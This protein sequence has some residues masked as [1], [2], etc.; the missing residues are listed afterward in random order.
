MFRDVLSICLGFQF[1][2]LVFQLVNGDVSLGYHHQGFTE[3]TKTS[4]V[5][6]VLKRDTRKECWLDGIACVLSEV[7][8]ISYLCLY[9]LIKY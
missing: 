8:T 4:I 2:F 1:F 6:T 9:I 5:S 3:K 7:R